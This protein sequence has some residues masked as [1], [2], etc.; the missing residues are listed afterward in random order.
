VPP[1]TFFEIDDLVRGKVGWDADA[2]VGDFIILRSSGV[3]VYN[4]CVA[5]DDALMGITTV[6]RA[7]EHLTNT[8]R[9]GLVLRALGYVV[10]Q[11]AHLS[12]VLGEDRS[13]LSKR[14]GATSLDQFRRAGFLPAAMINYL[15][16]LGW[17]DGTDKEIFS[18]PELVSLF[19]LERITKSPAIFDMTKLRWVNSQHMRMLPRAEL[20]ALLREYIV[21][22]Q[23]LFM[24]DGSAS[25]NAFFDKATELA[26]ERIEVIN[27]VA[28]TRRVRPQ[29]AAAT[30]ALA[31]S[32]ARPRAPLGSR[33][34]RSSACASHR[35]PP[36][37]ASPRPSPRSARRADPRLRA[38][39]HRRQRRGRRRA[40]RRFR[41]AGRGAHRVVRERGDAD[42]RR[43]GL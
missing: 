31:R 35:P 39:G 12:L 22:E 14:H 34:R 37:A 38:A 13:K 36:T 10:P 8:L 27:D 42:G 29:L 1:G 24:D 43:G 17:N 2:T 28:R 7:E 6:V 19:S 18:V 20:A 21:Q 3:P 11:Y 25:A 5:V 30:L 40:R 33:A 32:L 16:T 41:D 26:V 9:Q 15:T 4:F 23:G